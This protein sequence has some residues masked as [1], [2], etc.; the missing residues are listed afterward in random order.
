MNKNDYD[1]WGIKNLD[2]PEYLFHY[3]TVESLALILKS[4]SIKFSPLTNLDDLEEA[5]F[6]DL[7]KIG[8]YCLRRV[9]LGKITQRGLQC[10]GIML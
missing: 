4:H 8:N 9:V 1:P 5:K 7:K 3:T 6:N 10:A 2:P